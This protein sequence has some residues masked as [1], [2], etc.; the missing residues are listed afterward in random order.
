MKRNGCGHGIIKIILHYLAGEAME[1]H[2]NPVCIITIV[3]AETEIKNLLN[4][5]LESSCYTT[6]IASVLYVTSK[7]NYQ[8]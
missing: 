8:F 7:K 1:N 5:N 2:K 4:T 3:P 6:L